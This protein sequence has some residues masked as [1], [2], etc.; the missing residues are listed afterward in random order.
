MDNIIYEQHLN[1]NDIQDHGQLTN[2]DQPAYP[3]LQLPLY[4]KAAQSNDRLAFLRS[5]KRWL[6][7][8][9]ILMHIFV[10]SRGKEQ[11]EHDNMAIVRRMWRIGK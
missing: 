7:Y 2:P 8:D 9:I 5:N 10:L 6:S 4:G 3:P 1:K 11:Q